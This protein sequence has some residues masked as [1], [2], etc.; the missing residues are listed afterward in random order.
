MEP[1]DHGKIHCKDCIHAKWDMTNHKPPRIKTDTPGF[2]NLNYQKVYDMTYIFPP[3]WR[4]GLI[5]AVNSKTIHYHAKP[6][7]CLFHQD[8]QQAIFATEKDIIKRCIEIAESEEE[9]AGDPPA[10]IASLFTDRDTAVQA[11]RAAVRGTKNNIA[12]K[13]RAA[14]P[15]K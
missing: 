15:C 10:K 5:L 4:S 13:I 2:C 7:H 11:L 3:W 8:S 12:K 1:L 9:L 14:F 6:H